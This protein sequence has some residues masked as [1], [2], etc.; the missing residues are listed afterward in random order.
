MPDTPKVN[1]E[2]VETPVDLS[3]E[4]IDALTEVAEK[5]TE[6]HPE[7]RAS[8]IATAAEVA[9]DQVKVSTIKTVSTPHS[10]EE[11]SLTSK[12]QRQ[13]SLIWETTQRLIAV[14]VIWTALFISAYTSVRGAPD[15]Q[16]A[17]SIFLFGVANLVI[18][19]Y[20]GRTNHQKIGGVEQG[21]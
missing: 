17:S 20:F 7:R 11:D 1:V 3:P 14:S 10:Q 15:A 18:G 19:F 4:T 5:V 6:E 2:T 12:G 8:D 9:S 21:R 13:T 16:M